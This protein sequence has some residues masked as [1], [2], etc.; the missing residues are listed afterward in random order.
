[1]FELIN[2][3]CQLRQIW[4][5]WWYWFYIVRGRTCLTVDMDSV[6]CESHVTVTC[7]MYLIVMSWLVFWCWW[8]LSLSSSLPL[9]LSWFRSYCTGRF[10]P[11]SSHKGRERET[12]RN[13]GTEIPF[14]SPIPLL[15]LHTVNTDNPGCRWWLHS[16]TAVGWWCS[17]LQLSVYK[18][19]VFPRRCCCQMGFE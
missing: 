9:S 18:P 5:T 4:F 2:D 10:A 11:G 19:V 17:E 8:S 12:G 7:C 14:S 15:F 1:M 6:L 16:A 13:A 3:V